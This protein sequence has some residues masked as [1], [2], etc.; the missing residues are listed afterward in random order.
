M[1]GLV[2]RGVELAVYD[3]R[4][5][6]HGLYGVRTDDVPLAHAVLVREAALKYIADDL[7]IAMGM[8][9]ETFTGGDAIVVDYAQRPKSHVRR[10]V[11]VRKG[12]G[13]PGI[14]PA[15][16][17]VTAVAGLPDSN[18]VSFSLQF[19]GRDLRL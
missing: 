15:T 9:A 19:P 12:K 5:G 16:V 1:D 8:R 4:A 18:H 13:M 11:I 7:H 2:F 14:E 3:P 6:R 17:G 10:V